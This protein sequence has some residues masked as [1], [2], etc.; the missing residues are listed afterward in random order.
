MVHYYYLLFFDCF[1]LFLCFLT[2]LIKLILWLKFFFFSPQTKGR[3][4]M[5][6]TRTI[7]SYS[8]PVGRSNPRLGRPASQVRKVFLGGEVI[9]C[10]KCCR[11]GR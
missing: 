4:R 11:Q 3:Q 8:V 2:S 10:F 7:G 1:S 9:T 6:G 5:R